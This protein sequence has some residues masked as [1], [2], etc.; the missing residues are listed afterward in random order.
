MHGK[1]TPGLFITGTDTGVGKTYVTARIASALLAVG[2][3][4]AVYKPVLSGCSSA[5]ESLDHESADDGT[6]DDDVILWA[7]AGKPGDLQ[8][9]CPQ[10][11]AA[12]L[13]PHLAARAEG[14]EIDARL[15]RSGIEYWRERSDVVL[16]EGVGGLMTPLSDDEYVADLALDFGYPLIVVAPN[17]LGVINQTLQTLITAATFRDGLSVA[18]VVL[19]EI[20]P[21]DEAAA[22][23]STDSNRQELEA[24]CISPVLAHLGWG[25]TEFDSPLD[26]FELA[27]SHS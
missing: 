20:R 17:V 11:F 13:A 18:G 7:A 14:K 27:T 19:N 22:D 15:L 3:R 4:V 24:R 9:V 21:R 6:T 16:V 23:A 2:R 25:N 8:R 5:L 1:V 10:R 12:P 26:W